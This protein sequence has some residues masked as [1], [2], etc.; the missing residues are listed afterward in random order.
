[1][2]VPVYVPTFIS[3]EK[4]VYL[5]WWERLLGGQASGDFFKKHFCLAPKETAYQDKKN[6]YLYLRWTWEKTLLLVV[7]LISF[8]HIV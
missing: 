1:M 4:V 8:N 7:L 2:S 6:R 5:Q 3:S